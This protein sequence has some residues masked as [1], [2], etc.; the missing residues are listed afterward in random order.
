VGQ[1][2]RFGEYSIAGARAGRQ[3]GLENKNN[4][5]ELRRINDF[6]WLQEKFDASK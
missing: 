3:Y 5:E 6:N 1:D 4:L 2:A